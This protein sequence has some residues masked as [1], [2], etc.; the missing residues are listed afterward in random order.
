MAN[1][2]ADFNGSTPSD[3]DFVRHPTRAA[4][5][6]FIRDVRARL[7]SF[8]GVLSD[9]ETGDFKDNVI[10][11]AALADHP[12]RPSSNG[13][14]YTEVT[15]D[16]RGLVIAGS[17]T[18]RLTAP[19][20]FRAY[21]CARGSFVETV[22]AVITSA[23]SPLSNWPTDEVTR[24]DRAVLQKVFPYEF[25]VP[26]GV[27][28]LKVSV[29]G[30]GWSQQ[31]STLFGVTRAVFFNY[32]LAPG[33]KLFVWAGSSD[34]PSVIGKADYSSYATSE[35]R[36]KGL[37]DPAFVFSVNPPKMQYHPDGDNGTT[38]DPTGKPG[39]VLIEWYA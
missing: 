33:T 27:S 11:Q 36:Q 34:S 29:Y 23:P 14:N 38:A 37:G 39:S 17:K 15:V 6:S 35:G 19:R 12:D 16:R 1:L 24:T 4:L 5:P 10:P 9:I 7:K 26:A 3:A 21:F 28:R 25:V 30:G 8:W 2:G 22:D 13:D 20:L 31:N 32:A 18:I